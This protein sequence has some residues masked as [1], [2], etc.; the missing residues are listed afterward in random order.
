MRYYAFAFAVVEAGNYYEYYEYSTTSKEAKAKRRKCIKDGYKVS[1]IQYIDKESNPWG[2]T[3]F[4][5]IH[6]AKCECKRYWK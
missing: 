6:T 1:V 4:K 3:S 5:D 2:R